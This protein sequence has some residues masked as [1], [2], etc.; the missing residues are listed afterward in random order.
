MW[1][2][3]GPVGSE[4]HGFGGRNLGFSLV[5]DG[6]YGSRTKAA[7]LAVQHYLKIGE[8]GIYGSQTASTM[9]FWAETASDAGLGSTFYCHTLN[10]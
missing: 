8:D 3:A 9:K 6:V 1:A 10:G 4:P 5:V 7:V 2:G